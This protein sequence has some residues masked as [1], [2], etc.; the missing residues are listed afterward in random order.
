MAETKMLVRD[1]QLIAKRLIYLYS[2]RSAVD[3]LIRSL[4]EYAALLRSN[5]GELGDSKSA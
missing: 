2:R 3:K 1:P 4:E 5:Q